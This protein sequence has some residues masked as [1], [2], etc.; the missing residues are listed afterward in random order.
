MMRPV[1]DGLPQ[2]LGLVGEELTFLVTPSIGNIIPDLVLG[3][4][5]DG[6]TCAKLAVTYAEASLLAALEQ[7]REL[8]LPELRKCLFASSISVNRYIS[9]L[10]RIGGIQRNTNGLMRIGD[11]LRTDQCEI[12]AIEVKMR[13][14]REALQQAISYQS[15]SDQAYVVLDARQVALNEELFSSF[16]SANVGLL[17]QDGAKLT[18]VIRCSSRRRF[19]SNRVIVSQKLKIASLKSV[20]SRRTSSISHTQ[21]TTLA[22]VSHQYA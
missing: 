11:F 9:R 7:Y 20:T 3:E 15:F 22:D 1:A 19:S 4:W 12:V 16:E 21:I 8:S 18:R 17:L 14:W 6:A 13:R 5:Q 10:E 2:A